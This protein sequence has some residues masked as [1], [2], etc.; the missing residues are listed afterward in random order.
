MFSLQK[1]YIAVGVK[2]SEDIYNFRASLTAMSL[3]LNEQY[4]IVESHL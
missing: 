1:P 4:W 3:T 2:L